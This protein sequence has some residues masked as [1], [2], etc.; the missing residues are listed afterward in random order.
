MVAQQIKREIADML[1]RDKI[2]QQAILPETA[3]GTD[4]YLYSLTTI[5][6]VEVSVCQKGTFIF[7]NFL[8]LFLPGLCIIRTKFFSGLSFDVKQLSI[9]K[10][11]T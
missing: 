3:L 7:C 10:Y 5:S 4:K 2:L 8:N 1:L 11:V 9:E 6:D